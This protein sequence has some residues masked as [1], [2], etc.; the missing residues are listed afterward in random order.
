MQSLPVH[1]WRLPRLT[2]FVAFCALVVAGCGGRADTSL[3]GTFRMGEKVQIGPLTYT[4][5]E[6]GGKNALNDA[7]GSRPPQNRY[8][9]LRLSCVNTG[10]TAAT[11]PTLELVAADR[12]T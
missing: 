8:L 2:S 11:M 12:K 5:L 4:V 1:Q 9:L 10:T 7:P 6:S 3:L